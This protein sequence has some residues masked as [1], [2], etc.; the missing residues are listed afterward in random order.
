MTTPD[1][2]ISRLTG[3]RQIGPDR[4]VARCPAHDDST[5]SLSV[6]ISEDKI[7]I[8]CWAGCAPDDILGALGL[9]WTDLFADKWDAGYQAALA[10]GHKRR[11]KMLAEITQRDYA[12][13]V[14]ALAAAELDAGIE[15]DLA[16]RA[17]LALAV[18]I[19]KGGQA[20]G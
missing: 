5:P 16:D 18:H 14:V 7:L 11:Q 1:A 13:W 2:L 8:H 15:H 20:H 6:R 10:A 17:T 19:L 3:A 4:W 12:T 9:A